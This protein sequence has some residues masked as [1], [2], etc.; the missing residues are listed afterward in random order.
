MKNTAKSTIFNIYLLYPIDREDKGNLY[1]ALKTYSNI[2]IEI[3]AYLI[4]WEKM[5][6]LP[7]SYLY[8]PADHDI[9]IHRAYKDGLLTKKDISSINCKII[10]QCDLLIN[11]GNGAITDRDYSNIIAE[12]RCVK[13][14]EVPIYTMPDLSPHAIQAL[15][16]AIKLILRTE[17]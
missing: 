4:D 9:F 5:D 15:R 1:R 12:L 16:L 7:K 3:Q 8:V 2:G 11:F 10:K 6:G 13:Q 14:E 17:D